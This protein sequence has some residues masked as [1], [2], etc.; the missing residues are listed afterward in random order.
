MPFGSA[1]VVVL[2]VVL[3]KSPDGAT[4]LPRLIVPPPAPQP[5]PGDE[6]VLRPAGDGSGDLMYDGKRFRA[7]VAADGSVSFEA[8][9]ITDFTLL[10][11][12]PMRTQLGVPSLQSSL[13][14]LLKGKP[15]PPAPEPDERGPPAE[16]TQVIPEVSRYRP[17]P[18]EG[19]RTC[20]WEGRPML[21]SAVGRADATDEVM[22]MSGQDP[23][24][25][26]KANF[27]AATRERR[28][29]MA[30]KVHADNIRRAASELPARLKDIACDPRL[31]P[32]DRRGILIALRDEMAT[33][34][35]PGSDAV[36][37]I[38]EFLMQ[39]DGKDGVVCKPPR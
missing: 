7:R 23:L 30:A 15:P 25:F 20:K 6:I 34:T 3:G 27:L 29:Q 11:M 10:P 35:T 19:C 37:R 4:P 1:S 22:R 18:R 38:G 16:T 31:S 39:H 9:R 21:F 32:A 14:M 24:R 28:I 12:L 5:P 36:A 33:D 8:K 17:D 13:K 2:A 26:E